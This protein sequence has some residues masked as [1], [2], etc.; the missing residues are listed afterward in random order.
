MCWDMER[1]IGFFSHTGC[2]TECQNF[3]I[4]Q[5][6]MPVWAWPRGRDYFLTELEEITGV[7]M[8]LCHQ[9]VCVGFFSPF[10]V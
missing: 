4:W 5:K 9:G 2:H 8:V 6:G 7:I 1:G 10:F 3:N